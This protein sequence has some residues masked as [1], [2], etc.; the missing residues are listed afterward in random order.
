MVRAQIVWDAR[1]ATTLSAILTGA[2][3]VHQR[4]SASWIGKGRAGEDLT[5][6]KPTGNI[7]SR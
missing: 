6:Q 7:V 4:G 1:N 3:A 5:I 2:A